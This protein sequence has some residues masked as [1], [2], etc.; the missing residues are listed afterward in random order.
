V[1]ADGSLGSFVGNPDGGG[2]AGAAASYNHLLLLGPAAP[3]FFTTPSTMPGA[4]IEPLYLT[5]PYE[6]SIADSPRGQQ[7]IAHGI[8][9]AIEQYLGRTG[10]TVAPGSG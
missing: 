5:D 9:T 10:T 7:V 8:A 6:G 4:V 2:I 1:Q 3:G